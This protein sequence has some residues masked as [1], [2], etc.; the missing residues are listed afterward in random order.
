MNLTLLDWAKRL[1][2]DGTTADICELLAQTNEILTDSV[3]VQGNLPTGHRTTIRTGLP[4]VYYRSLNEGVATSKSTSAQVDEAVSI[5]E[6]RSEVDI[7]LADLHGNTAAFRLS[8]GQA[9]IEAMNQKMATGLFYGNPTGDPKEFQGLAPRYSSLSAGNGQNVLNYGGSGSTNTS[10]WLICWGDNTVFCPFPKG[11]NAGLLHE[12]LGRQTSYD[13]T[14]AAGST[15]QVG[16]RMEVYADRY[17]WKTGLVVKD[18]RYVVR[19][20]N[21]DVS[22]GGNTINGLAGTGA[23]GAVTNILHFMAKAIACLPSPAMGRCAFYVNRTVFSALM[24]LAME[25]SVSALSIQDA[26]TQFGKPGQMLSF[27]GIPLR[28]CDSLVN[29]ETAVA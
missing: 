14:D 16:K 22:G 19:I 7:D 11:S 20:C 6:A 25:K 28:Q 9:F 5:M 23:P 24:R 12:D 18:W 1:D 8:E 13:V 27:M 29:T 3:H 2:P 17:Q 15:H 4:Q 26:I 10:V 21:V